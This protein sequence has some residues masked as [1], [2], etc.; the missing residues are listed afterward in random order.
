MRYCRVGFKL[1][2]V[3]VEYGRK[4]ITK[5]YITKST[6]S[7]AH[8]F[9]SRFSNPVSKYNINTKKANWKGKNRKGVALTAYW[10]AEYQPQEP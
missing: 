5:H 9:I 6:N 7:E 2:I 3:N 1:K 8:N 4:T 10:H